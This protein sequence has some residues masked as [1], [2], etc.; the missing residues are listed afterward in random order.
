M[1]LE[2]PLSSR[3]V[4]RYLDADKRV[5]TIDDDALNDIDNDLQSV[6]NCTNED[7]IVLFNVN[8]TI[9]P[10]HRVIIPWNLTLSTLSERME[11]KDGTFPK[12]ESKTN[13]TCPDNDEGVFFAR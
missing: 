5:W 1:N 13:F 3:Q 9:R 2:C 7:D 8:Q 4:N 6:V 10:S 12:I 11:L